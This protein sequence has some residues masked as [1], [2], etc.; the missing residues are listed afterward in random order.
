MNELWPS[1]ANHN[2]EMAKSYRYN[3]CPK[4]PYIFAS[5][6]LPCFEKTSSISFQSSKKSCTSLQEANY[7]KKNF[8][9]PFSS[10]ES[11]LDS[12]KRKSMGAG[13]QATSFIPPS[14]KLIRED[15][16]KEE[17]ILVS[18]DC[19]DMNFYGTDHSED[20][21]LSPDQ[22]GSIMQYQELNHLDFTETD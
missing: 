20:N 10:L 18:Y 8:Q 5:Q 17:V 7:D 4:L 6:D 11:L 12:L 14:K 2:I 1:D 19:S 3:D 21:N 9:I 13:N 16:E 15:T 22:W